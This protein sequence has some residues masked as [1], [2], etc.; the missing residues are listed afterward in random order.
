MLVKHII[1]SLSANIRIFIVFIIGIIYSNSR[2]MKIHEYQTKKFS[3]EV[4][5]P[6]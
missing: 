5:D 6:C 3:P 4:W 2:T 1:S